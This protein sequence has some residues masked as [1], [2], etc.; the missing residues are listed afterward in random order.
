[1][2][3]RREL[4]TLDPRDILLRMATGN[5]NDAYQNCGRQITILTNIHQRSPKETDKTW[6]W[7]SLA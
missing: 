2:N 6:G 1:M 5:L 7:W 3:M 4:R